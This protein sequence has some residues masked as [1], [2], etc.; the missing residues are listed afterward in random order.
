MSRGHFDNKYLQVLDFAQ[1]MEAEGL[2]DDPLHE[3]FYKHLEKV[4]E[5]MQSIERVR[6]GD[7]ASAVGQ[8]QATLVTPSP[9][10][11]W[12]IND[13]GELGVFA[14]GKAHF[15]YKGD[16]LRYSPG[17]VKYRRVRKREFGECQHSIAQIDVGQPNGGDYYKA[18]ASLNEGKVWVSEGEPPEWPTR[19]GPDFIG[20]VKSTS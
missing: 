3:A 4:A 6:G 9:E 5:A 1:Q 13:L 10:P 11:I 19:T 16:C 14:N 20:F 15:L 18:E 7:Q 2:C 12:I 17:D 8:I